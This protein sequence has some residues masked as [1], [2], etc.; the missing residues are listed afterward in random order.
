MSADDGIEQSRARLITLEAIFIGG[1]ALKTQRVD[2]FQIGI[3]FDETLRIEQIVDSFL[4]REG[5]MIIAARTNPQIF[6]ELDFVHDFAA[7]RTFLEKPVRNVALL[8]TL[9]FE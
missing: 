6:D 5:E 1:H 7:T 8:P 9:C 4:G 2:G 3:H